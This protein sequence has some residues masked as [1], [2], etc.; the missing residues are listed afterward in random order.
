M[1]RKK[2]KSK[3]SS[4]HQNKRKQISGPQRVPTQ[5]NILQQA[6]ALHEA[7]RL[8]PAEKLYRQILATQP[9]HPQALHY[10]GILAHQLGENELSA[11]LINNALKCSPDYVDAH[12]N[13]GITFK[14]L[15]KLD[16][17]VASFQRA[18]NLKPDDAV[19]HYNL[20]NT[21]KEQGKLNE[22]IISY[23]QTL[24]LKPDYA[25][26][27]YNLGNVLNEQGKPAEAA[28]C[29]RQVLILK[30][31]YAE[32]YSNLGN[33]LKEQ[34]KLDEAIVC[35]QQALT[36]K[37]DDALIHYNL[38]NTFKDQG[39]LDEAV[40]SF[41]QALT[42]KPDFAEAHHSLGLIFREFGKMDDAIACYRKALS[43]KPDYARAYRN[44]SL[45]VKCTDINDDIQVME[46]L[47]SKKEETSDTDR[48]DLGFA[49]AK[50]FENLGDYDKSFHFIHESNQLK[51]RSYEY[52]IQE[53]HDLFKRI[54]ET[55][56][57]DFFA[58]HHDSGL[59]EKTPIFILGMPRS[60]TT[61]IEQIL[62]SHPLVFGAGELAI[63]ANLA[64]NIC[65]ESA[66]PQFPECVQDLDVDAFE[67]MGADYVAQIREYSNVAK[68]ITDKM[69]HNFLYVG[70][71]KTIL[72]AA[73]VIHCLRD[74]MDTCFSLFK[75]EFAGAHKY[76]YDMVELGQY[77]NLYHDLMTYWEKVL[78]GFM[79]TLR[80]EQLVADQQGQTK[81]LLDFCRLPWDDACLTFHK[82]QR[83]VSTASLA[84]VRQPI[85]KD[86][87]GLW[88]HYEKQLE[89]LQ[90][91][92]YR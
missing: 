52:S 30:P 14:R 26:A 74:P 10:L 80:Y 39:K 71:I 12:I 75:T 64:N 85:Y 56:S 50:I 5:Q 69:P 62:A 4:G 53:D 92:L 72:P 42:L 31:E 77:Y 41:Q 2:K 16:E 24:T 54:K 23:R 48:I 21:L 44:L 91:A 51:R 61:L 70:L 68:H 83:R 63:L 73:K 87:V 79:Y 55:F 17:A 25:E 35:F 59:Q 88:K 34:E 37:P 43:L 33:V 32:A 47:Y 7:G 6:L 45:I 38:G 19:A 8:Q 67:R 60:G 15:G 13:L 84:Q 58:S 81:S 65:T 9:D 78:P 20:G 82:T 27:Y 3:R 89:P 29:Y 11:E 49:L 86:S 46:N 18:L 66:A 76:A 90:N 1:A 57:P 22:A 40:A 36:L 28:V